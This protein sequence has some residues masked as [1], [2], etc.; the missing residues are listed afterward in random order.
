MAAVF[1]PTFRQTGM[2]SYVN[3]LK[4][5]QWTRGTMIQSPPLAENDWP[6]AE[7][8]SPGKSARDPDARS[9][10]RFGS[11]PI[12]VSTE[13]ATRRRQVAR[14]RPSFG[15]RMFRSIARFSLAVLIGVAATL[16]WQS[17]GDVAGEV[18]VT[19]APALA[20]LV[21]A[22]TPKSPVEAAA[23]TGRMQQLEP[24]ASNLDV[25]RR[26]VDQLAAK[27]DQMAQ[28]IAALQVVEEDIRQKIS[29]TPPPP[30][31][32]PQAAIPQQK[33]AQPKVQSPA[34]QSSSVPRPTPGGPVLLTR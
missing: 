31:P 22:S 26:S 30:A 6:R 14:S 18:L 4:D 21:S 13:P 11:R 16:G 23:F 15:R 7:E 19:R 2:N 34:V 17:Y 8:T 3:G 32:A 33:P 9:D 29:F 27:Q 1:P 12:E 20:W 24:L 28:S 10:F 25:V 5:G